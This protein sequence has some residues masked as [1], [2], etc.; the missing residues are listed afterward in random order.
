MLKN[1]NLVVEKNVVSSDCKKRITIYNKEKEMKKAENKRFSA[2]N[3]IEHSFDGICRF[4][5]N[6][7]SKEQVRQALGIQDNKLSSVLDSQANPIYDFLNDVVIQ[8]E[9]TP[10]TDWKSYT[11]MLV[12]KDCDYNLEVVEKKLRSIYPRGN[13]YGK[14]MKPYRALLAEINKDDNPNYWQDILNKLS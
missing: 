14:L 12:L 1:R 6:L 9:Q 2:T 4:E 11:R 10:T 5:L 13:N 3:G 8:T 7:N